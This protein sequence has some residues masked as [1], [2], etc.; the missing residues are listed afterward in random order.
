MVMSLR[1]AV[2]LYM[3]FILVLAPRLLTVT[4]ATSDRGGALIER[5]FAYR[6]FGYPGCYHYIC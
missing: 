4:Q 5:D 1:K 3:W 2:A 6:G